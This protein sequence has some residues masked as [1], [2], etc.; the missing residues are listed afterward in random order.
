MIIVIIIIIIIMKHFLWHFKYIRKCFLRN[1]K[2][3]FKIR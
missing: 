2:I 3:I 1:W